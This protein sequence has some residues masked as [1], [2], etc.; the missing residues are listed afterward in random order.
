MNILIF[1]SLITDAC[2][3]RRDNREYISFAGRKKI[4][5][6]CRSLE[7]LG[8]TVDVCSTSYAKSLNKT[9]VEVISPMVR[10]IHAPT[11]GFFGKMSFLKR[12]VGMS[13]N[14]YWICK[15]FRKYQLVVFYN[16]H[17]E[18]FLPAYVGKRFF[19]LRILMDYEDGLFLDKGYQSAF[20]RYL[21]KAAYRETDGFFLVNG[22]L[23]ERIE[24]C[25]KGHKPTLVLNGL[26]DT[27]LLKKNR[28][29]KPGARTELA[30]T[31]NF[32]ESFGLEELLQYVRYLP[33]RFRLTI[34]G[35]ASPEE[36][37][38][39]IEAMKGRQNIRFMGRVDSSR[40]EQ[41]FEKIEICIL[42]NSA[43]SDWNKT[44]F[45]SKLFDYLS[46]NRF[47]LSTGNP[48]LQPY[49]GLSN[50]V[51][52]KDFPNDL[53]KLEQIME[54]RTPDSY[55]LFSLHAE[56][57]KSLELFIQKLVSSAVNEF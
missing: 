3:Q 25:S 29:W 50:F 48:V 11:V 38:A 2:L 56:T 42:L 14:L 27:E 44:N 8:H 21:E 13:F 35:Q 39:V 4:G 10:I 6:L 30:F 36:E 41:V 37:K 53:K 24:A 32:S 26:L 19:G 28:E 40:F 52:L 57:L 54:K 15:H 1:T 9:F 17:K 18:Y 49:Y 22:S 5:L 47:V 45:P 33:E 23:K 16:Y 55:E 20:Y 7:S 12:P 43:A 46:R 31:G 51:L 34:T